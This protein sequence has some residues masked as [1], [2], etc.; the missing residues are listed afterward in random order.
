[1]KVKISEKTLKAAVKSGTGN[2]KITINKEILKDVL[3]DSRVRKGVVIEISIPEV[4]NAAVNAIVLNREAL[5]S[6]K[7]SGQDLTVNIANA[8]TR[9]YAVNI[10]ASEL[11]KITAASKELNLSVELT[12][13]TKAAPKSA[14]VLS[15]GTEGTLPAG[16]VVTVPV[17]GTLSIPAGKKVYIYHRNIKTG[18][19]EEV[20]NNPQT[21]AENGNL[22]LSA[23]RGG[24]YVICTEKV[25]DAVKL[26]DRVT[27]SVK[28]N[29]AKGSKVN[30]KVSLPLEL[31]KVSAFKKE[32]PLG[33]EEAKV[34]YTVSN[35][36][37]AD[38][39]GNGTVT[40]K[41]KGT[42]RIT[43]SVILENGQKKSFSKNIT[44]K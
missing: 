21:I 40:A 22:K 42:V 32:E 34:S 37:I 29:L 14:G 33:Q 2:L 19:L 12:K 9:G 5:L 24:N 13:D 10:P 4:K 31:T 3:T 15:V 8:N 26:V 44:V 1:M 43:V 39:S 16:I 18:A 23:L 35:K 17:K 28:A 38:V 6:A 7:K 30:V 27:V 36:D 20:A 25:K 41:K 11:K